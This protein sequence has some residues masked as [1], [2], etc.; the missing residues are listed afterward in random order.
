[1]T[2]AFPAP[3]FGYAGKWFPVLDEVKR[4]AYLVKNNNTPVGVEYTPGY[5]NLSP[6]YRVVTQNEF[7]TAQQSGSLVWIA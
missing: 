1:M 6:N 4:A 3:Q 7:Y 5:I 2:H